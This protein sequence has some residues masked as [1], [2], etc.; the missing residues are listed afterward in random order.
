M[1]SIL[2]RVWSFLGLSTS[3]DGQLGISEPLPPDCEQQNTVAETQD[4]LHHA[5]SCQTHQ[6]P[7]ASTEDEE[8]PPGAADE[9]RNGT[10]HVATH[11]QT[12]VSPSTQDGDKH[13]TLRHAV[14]GIQKQP[15][16]KAPHIPN[17]PT[18]HE[19]GQ[20][21]RASEVFKAS[22]MSK[23][24]HHALRVLAEGK[25]NSVFNQVIKNQHRP[26]PSHILPESTA[27]HQLHVPIKPEPDVDDLSISLCGENALTSN[28]GS[29]KPSDQDNVKEKFFHIVTENSS[30]DVVH[31]AMF[32]GTKQGIQ[33]HSKACDGILSAHH[34]TVLGIVEQPRRPADK[35]PFKDLINYGVSR[36]PKR[37]A[38]SNV[39]E[40]GAVSERSVTTKSGS[41][42]AIHQA[43]KPRPGNQINSRSQAHAAQHANPEPESGVEQQYSPARKSR[44]ANKSRTV[45]ASN[46]TQ[47]T[48][49][50]RVAKQPRPAVYEAY[51][52]ELYKPPN[53]RA[54]RIIKCLEKNR[55]P[56]TSKAEADTAMRMAQKLLG[57]HNVVEAEILGYMSLDEQMKR[58]G[59]SIT[60]VRRVVRN[61]KQVLLGIFVKR[62][63]K[64]LSIFFDCKLYSSRRRTI[65]EV[66][67]IFYGISE[68]T[69]LAAIAFENIHNLIM[70]WA[71][72]KKGVS[73][74]RS[75]CA[76]I[77]QGL[78]NA[79]KKAKF[80]ELKFAKAAEA[81]E[82]AEREEQ[83]RIQRQKELDR[84]RF[85]ED[86][87]NLTDRPIGTAHPSASEHQPEDS[88]SDY[89]TYLPDTAG[90]QESSSKNDNEDSQ[91]DKD[92]G[93]R[94]DSGSEN[95]SDI[96]QPDVECDQE[97]L[98]DH[99][100]EN[101]D[102]ERQGTATK[103]GLDG[104]KMPRLSKPQPGPFLSSQRVS[105]S[106]QLPKRTKAVREETPWES[107]GQLIAFRKCALSIAERYRK[108]LGLTSRRR[109][110]RAP[111]KDWTA[112]REGK[113]DG[114]KIDIREQAENGTTR[115]QKTTENKILL[116]G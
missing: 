23:Q 58:A 42:E 34:S 59:K 88:D 108:K 21:V 5:S 47:Q 11:R 10:N 13:V 52:K 91:S 49:P 40:E 96:Y 103:P 116:M 92:S 27:D 16:R 38:K 39:D 12:Q 45:K 111:I 107:S 75:Y 72:N 22:K 95:G 102:V 37:H 76:G 113:D 4:A 32:R 6:V 64:A 3:E 18:E 44:S 63:A 36:G 14:A 28:S 69:A 71:R 114:R 46:C 115:E 105:S 83:E 8:I 86:D 85:P 110:H 97:E 68:N 90:L 33:Q 55:H 77:A 106:L 19:H 67:F 50:R 62:L 109:Q 24:P 17:T 79:A 70:E 57:E 53:E 104:S 15:N 31:D 112:Y 66:Y 48:R 9:D 99:Q 74:T 73:Y 26:G 25:G 29:W 54:L 94:S 51:I 60:S 41:S 81:E 20:S 78:A 61:G 30:P 98:E 1:G 56:T 82:L 35:E 100:R 101:V 65:E 43:K 80:D 2:H 7:S 84:L 87:S 93:D 89:D